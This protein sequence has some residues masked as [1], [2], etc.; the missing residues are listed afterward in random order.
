M[1]RT[2]G[3]LYGIHQRNK[4]TIREGYME[5]FWNDGDIGIFHFKCPPDFYYKGAD[6]W[7]ATCKLKPGEVYNDL[8]WLED[9][10]DNL[11]IEL[12]VKREEER[13]EELKEKI[14]KYERK[15]ETIKSLI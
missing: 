5:K 9:R 15:I 1:G 12:F 7:S 11:A 3:Y 8:L 4:L 10:N 13:I 6:V 14:H 2:Y